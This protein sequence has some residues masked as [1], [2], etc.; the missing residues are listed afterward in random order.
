MLSVITPVYNGERF[1]EACINVVINQNC[2][3][4]EHIIVDGGSSDR[5]VEII[6][7]YAEQYPHIQWI[8]EKDQGQ[9]D[10][11]NKGIA[12][13]KQK[14]ISFLNVDDFYAPNILNWVLEIFRTLPEPSLLVGNCNVWNSKGELSFINKP[15]K[16]ELTSLLLGYEVNP[17]P[18]NP[19]AY[20]YHASLHQ[21]IGLYQIDEHYAMDLEFILKAVEFATT[22]YV[23]KTL[24]NFRFIEGTK[25]VS[26]Y[27]AGQ[28]LARRE[29]AMKNYRDKL[30]QLQRWYVS[31]GYEFHR[32]KNDLKYRIKQTFQYPF[33]HL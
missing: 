21:K 30:P 9:S 23:D 24:G 11:M 18:I 10:A 25:T 12:M 22:K 32:I 3:A 26:D 5:T 27:Q 28:S 1:I 31:A 20:F 14:I 16:M 6:Q 17:Y 33:S 29:A 4:V 8:S 19:S 15:K 13:A 2:P 7:R